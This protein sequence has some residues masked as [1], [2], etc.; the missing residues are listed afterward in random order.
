MRR[1]PAR[2]PRVGSVVDATAT[3][4][5]PVLT[6]AI[7]CLFLVYG[8]VDAA[9]HLPSERVW[10]LCVSLVPSAGVL[11]LYAFSRSPWM[12]TTAAPRLTA[13]GLVIVALGQ[14]STLYLGRAPSDLAL[15]LVLWCVSGAAAMS[16]RQFALVNVFLIPTWLVGARLVVPSDGWLLAD[17]WTGAGAA[18]FASATIV[19]LGRAAGFREQQRLQ[20]DLA[21]QAY[22]DALTGA[23]SRYGATV[24]F[25]AVRAEAARQRAPLFAVF[26]D[27]DGLKRMN[28]VFGHDSGDALIAAT[29]RAIAASARPGDLVARWGGD[30][31]VVIG[32]GEGPELVR[33]LGSIERRVN[34]DIEE[35]GLPP[36]TVSLGVA[37]CRADLAHIDTLVNQADADMYRRRHARRTELRVV[38]DTDRASASA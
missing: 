34:A 26:V 19:H 30:E 33:L 16:D 10:R 17:G 21:R 24:D 12:T 29:G 14:V 25:E 5:L 11:G 23:A 38:R 15:L 27:V 3:R 18:T 20:E 22:S 4:E 32:V 36:A 28:D 35:R 31:F 8:T 7:G 37:T 1:H 2:S 9:V 13:L 6:I